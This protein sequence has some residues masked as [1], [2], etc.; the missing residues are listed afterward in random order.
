M[1]SPS[2]KFEPQVASCSCGTNKFEVTNR[3]LARFVCHCEVCQKF[4][5]K[6]FSDVTVALMRDVNLLDISHT[7]FSRMKAPPNIKRG[8]CTKC[9]KPSLEM[10]IIDQLA[11]IPTSTYPE[12]ELL[13]E[14]S[15][16]AFYHRRVADID[17]NLPKHEGFF[18]SQV[19]IISLL[20]KGLTRKLCKGA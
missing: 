19:A 6:A 3:P 5:G 13:P 14:P 8:K 9:H 2:S 16:H 15:L 20:G 18:K 12:P 10:G 1:S 7:E 4:T 11:F 17:D